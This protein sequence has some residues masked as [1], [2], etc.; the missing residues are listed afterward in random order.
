MPG[1]WVALA[2]DV[3]QTHQALRCKW[4]YLEH[5]VKVNYNHLHL[6]HYI[7]FGYQKLSLMNM[8]SS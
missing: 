2:Q 1:L 3:E 7:Y 4:E 5:L 8:N 6:T